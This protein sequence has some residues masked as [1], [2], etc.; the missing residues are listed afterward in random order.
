MHN[1]CILSTKIYLRLLLQL[2]VS[3][4]YQQIVLYGRKS[5]A[6]ALTKGIIHGINY[7]LVKKKIKKKEILHPHAHRLRA[8][9]ATD[10]SGVK[11]VTRYPGPHSGPTLGG[12]TTTINR[13]PHSCLS[14][15]V[16]VP[17]ALGAS[18]CRRTQ[19]PGVHLE[20][21]PPHLPAT[22]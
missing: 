22:Q 15:S 7:M 18:R 3:H 2:V 16:C 19:R 20:T 12:H 5:S 6:L 14:S 11:A 9:S 8:H 1:I 21:P 4:R 13:S 17:P 10:P